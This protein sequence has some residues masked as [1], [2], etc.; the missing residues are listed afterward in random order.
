M[1]TASGL[2]MLVAMLML[3]AVGGGALKLYMD[4]QSMAD[5]INDYS[6][7]LTSLPVAGD[8]GQAFA[9]AGEKARAGNYS[10]ARSELARGRTA[11]S[12]TGPAIGMPGMSGMP[13]M[14]QMPG[15]GGPSP[16][17][18]PTDQE[19]ESALQQLP[20]D[21]RPFFEKRRELLRR[22][23]AVSMAARRVDEGK[24]KPYRERIFKAAAAGDEAGVQAA[25]D[26]ARRDMGLGRRTGVEGGRGGPGGPGMPRMM[27]GPGMP[28]MG[29]GGGTAADQLAMARQVLAQAQAAG[30]DVSKVAA[31]VD[32]ADRELKAGSPEKAAASLREAFQVAQAA[33]M[34]GGGPPR[35][36]GRGGGTGGFPGG[37]GGSPGRQ[38]GSGRFAARPGGP[39]MGQPGRG[40]PGMGFPGPGPG[41]GMG[42]PAQG[43]GQGSGPQGMF[44]NVFGSLMGAMR[45]DSGVLAALMDDL[46]NAGLA[47]REKNQDQVRDIL[48]AARN[49]VASLSKRRET[50]GR[51][52][53]AAQGP[54]PG[55][56]AEGTAQGPATRPEGLGPVGPRQGRQRPGRQGP[57]GRPPAGEGPGGQG[58]GG[59]FGGLPMMNMMPG[60]FDFQGIQE[61]IGRA[62]DDV[63]K[64]PDEQYAQQREGL[65]QQFMWNLVAAVTGQ[66]GEPTPQE[67]ATGQGALSLPPLQ[68]PAEEPQD[69]AARKELEK[70]IRDRLRLLQSPCAALSQVGADMT[71]VEAALSQARDAVN[72][73]T[74]VDAAKTTNQTAD[75]VWQLTGNY[76]AQLEAL[77]AQPA[78]GP[79]GGGG[80]Q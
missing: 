10:D 67:G 28:G 59:M 61:V 19:V 17:A 72:A 36:M 1:R 70:Q 63:R 25:M 38:G 76:Q 15:I 75:M 24:W 13:G 52:L 14:G 21:A 68:V 34:G 35:G 65:I 42:M 48:A 64:M 39:G 80:E 77:K 45:E 47:I 23:L 30:M 31:I 41:M 44:P 16:G 37:G 50:V 54:F 73:G 18:E 20:A 33:M 55:A 43:L 78:V 27:T 9:A 71:Q 11:A 79:P 6:T 57:E 5:V 29:M 66:F 32:R 74:L 22:A 69:P 51:E 7:T 49:K 40:G 46:E 3:L 2:A 53:M 8:A 4:R 56:G 62:L 12:Q 26:D 60:M 58:P